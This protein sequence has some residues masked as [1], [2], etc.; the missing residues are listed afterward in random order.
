MST[1][2]D[3]HGGDIYPAAYRAA[4]QEQAARLKEHAAK[5]GL[6]FEAYLVPGM[7]EWA[8]EQVEKGHFIDPSE[9]AFVAMQQFMELQKYPDVGRELLRRMLQASI[10]DPRPSI[11]AEEVFAS[12]KEHIKE[13]SK[14]TAAQWEKVG[15]L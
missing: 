9:V 7:A 14:L 15:E 2:N 12:L 6:K 10:D 8:L 13:F 11:P 3:V 1:E 4:Q 5:A